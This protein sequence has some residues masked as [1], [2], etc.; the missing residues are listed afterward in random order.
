[1]QK[2]LL[3]LTMIAG[4]LS[5]QPPQYGADRDNAV[6]RRDG[7]RVAWTTKLAGPVQG[8]RDPHLV[9]DNRRVY[10]TDGDGITA[11]D[12]ATGKVLWRSKGP[13]DR[14]L[15][16]GDLL[17]AADCGLSDRIEKE[18]RFFTARG[19]ADGKEV[20]R[21]ELPKRNEFD[22][23]PIREVAGMFLVQSRGWGK[24]PSEAFL[25]TR[26]GKVWYRNEREILDAVSADGILVLNLGESVVGLDEQARRIW[27]FPNDGRGPYA[28]RLVQ[29]P[30]G[31]LVAYY[32]SPNS[33]SGVSLQRFDPCKGTVRYR[34]TC[35]PL[36]VDH[37]K[38]RHEA[39]VTVEKRA[40]KIVSKA[41]GGTFSELRD[42]DT[43]KLLERRRGE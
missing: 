15:L 27:V 43:G 19:V 23:Y 3:S 8:V 34:A 17:L 16:S 31:D 32:Y 7:D 24:V 2:L 40:L 41:T 5:A 12:A 29:V 38:Y 21:V 30:G 13:S 18:G 26:A 10:V 1:M 11:L 39:T 33:D 22:P 28:G 20:F 6:S 4:G 42:L 36:G 37:S 25:V 14:L 9:S 35:K